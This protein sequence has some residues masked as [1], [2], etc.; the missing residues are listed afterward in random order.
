MLDTGAASAPTAN[1]GPAPRAKP[2]IRAM[3]VVAT[4][5]GIGVS[6]RR[7][8][9]PSAA[10]AAT[11]A[12]SRAL[13]RLRSYQPKAAGE[14]AREPGEG[15]R[16]PGHARSLRR[17]RG[18]RH[19]QRL[20]P[21]LG[22]DGAGRRRGSAR[23]RLRSTS[24]RRGCRRRSRRRSARRRRAARRDRR[25]AP[26]TRHRESPRTPRLPARANSASQPPNSSFRAGSIPRVGSSRQTRP[27]SPSPSRPAITRA[28]ASRSR[29]PPERSRG[30]LSAAHARPTASSARRPA[31]PGSSSATRSR[32]S[33]SAG[34]CGRRAHPRGAASDP[35]AGSSSPAAARS[36]VLLPAPFRPMSATRSPGASSRSSPRSTSRDPARRV[37]LDPEVASLERRRLRAATRQ[38]TAETPQGARAVG[39]VRRR[40]LGRVGLETAAGEFGARGLDRDRRRAEP[41]EREQP[42]TGRRELGVGVQRPLAIGGGQAVEADAPGVD[43]DHPVGGRQAALQ[44]VLGEQDRPSPTPR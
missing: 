32:T 9:I 30:S 24:R 39:A 35:R 41:G 18:R 37:E 31:S 2:V 26:R 34:L 13:G 33:M 40:C 16:L 10:R 14:D 12:T 1:P 5:L 4:T 29:S 21:L 28:R 19:A 38:P 43:G 8:A 20:G 42:R 15:D 17:A 6:T 11:R 44:A 22:R 36:R 27:G 25:P 23:P 7:P 3:S